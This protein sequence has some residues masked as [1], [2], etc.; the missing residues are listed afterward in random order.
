M[1]GT[2]AESGTKRKSFSGVFRDPHR[3]DVGEGAY[4]D[5][6]V[7]VPEHTAEALERRQVEANVD[8]AHLECRPIDEG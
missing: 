6:L 4:M 2:A 8:L 5:V 1:Q 7:A 3:Q